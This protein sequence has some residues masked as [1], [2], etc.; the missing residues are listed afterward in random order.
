MDQATTQ[1]RTFTTAANGLGAAPFRRFLVEGVV[2]VSGTHAM[3]DAEE[4]GA[5]HYFMTCDYSYT[6]QTQTFFEEHA[7]L[8]LNP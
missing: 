3:P 2:G 7:D 4:C 6:T 5:G 1:R 8:N